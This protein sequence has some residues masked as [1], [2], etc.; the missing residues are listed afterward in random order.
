MVYL[1]ICLTRYFWQCID[2]LI[3]KHVGEWEIFRLLIEKAKGRKS[4]CTILEQGDYSEN[5]TRW[6]L[7]YFLNRWVSTENLISHIFLLKFFSF[8][9]ALLIFVT[10]LVVREISN[11]WRVTWTL[12]D[13]RYT[14]YGN[15]GVGAEFWEKGVAGR[16]NFDWR[17]QYYLLSSVNE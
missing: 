15:V 17:V 14:E 3:A 8:V 1:V 11:Q 2:S 9:A 4:H 16:L 7:S 6:L 13:T 10:A 5:F 12:T